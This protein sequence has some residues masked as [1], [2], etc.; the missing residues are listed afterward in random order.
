MAPKQTFEVNMEVKESIEI[1]E[2]NA[3]RL[4]VSMEP[5][6]RKAGEAIRNLGISFG[7]AAERGEVSA[8][9]LRRLYEGTYGIPPTPEAIEMQIEWIKKGMP[10]G[11]PFYGVIVGPLTW[12]SVVKHWVIRKCLWLLEKCGCEVY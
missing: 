8:K 4:G 9:R 5:A 3:R 12:G 1:I 7:E 10:V 11:A 2:E 6:A